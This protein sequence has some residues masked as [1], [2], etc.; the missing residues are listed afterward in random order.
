MDKVPI[1]KDW[2]RGQVFSFYDAC[3]REGICLIGTTN[4]KGPEEMTSK[5][6]YSIVSRILGRC[7]FVAFNG[8]REDDYRLIRRKYDA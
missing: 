8:G 7:Q 2:A 3:I 1:D 4:L 6:D 5:F